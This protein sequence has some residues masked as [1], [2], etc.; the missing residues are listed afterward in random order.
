M[1]KAN[2]KPITW[3]LLSEAKARVASF[4]Q[5]PEIAEQRLT[6]WLL[7]GKLRWR[8]ECLD[9]SKQNHDPG[10]GDP[11]FWRWPTY[12][13]TASNPGVTLPFLITWEQSKA[14]RDSCDGQHVYTFYRIEVAEDDLAKLMPAGDVDGDSTKAWITA[15]VKD[16]KAEGEI[17]DGIT[18]T[19]F[20]QLLEGQIKAAARRGDAVKPV[21]YRHIANSLELWG[22]WPISSIK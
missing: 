13:P 11:D 10:S 22:L 8:S 20:A 16:M 12:N 14:W 9:G 17:P 21:G 18:K 1:A 4:Y 19:K 5:S 6:Q 3:I 7:A 2:G 15:K